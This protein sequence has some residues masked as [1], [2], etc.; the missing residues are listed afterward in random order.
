MQLK[1]GH[2]N[3]IHFFGGQSLKK[4]QKSLEKNA[5]IRTLDRSFLNG[6]K[7]LVQ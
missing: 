1:S 3:D 6:L 5:L 2:L 7:W 4:C